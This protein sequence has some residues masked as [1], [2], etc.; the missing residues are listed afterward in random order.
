MISF[1]NKINGIIVGDNDIKSFYK[2]LV[3]IMKEF[4]KKKYDGP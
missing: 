3:V 4:L 2:E 1:Q